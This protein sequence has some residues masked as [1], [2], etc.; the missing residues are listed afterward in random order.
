MQLSTTEILTGHIEEVFEALSDFPRAERAAMAR[1]VTVERL[2]ALGVP[3]AGV[4]WRLGFF[5]RGRDRQAEMEVTKFTRPTVIRFEGHVGGLL[6]ETSVACRVADSNA[7]EVTVATK[8]RA[9]SMSA[10]VLVQSLKIAR[11]RI[12]QRYR[13]SIRRILREVEQSRTSAQT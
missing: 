9:K 6:F 4:K 13:K 11:T 8:L 3:S 7:T 12:A 2:D 5:A 10:R 1:G